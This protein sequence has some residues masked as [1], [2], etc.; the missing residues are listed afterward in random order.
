MKAEA[1]ETGSGLELPRRRS[2]PL[3]AAVR[4]LRLELGLLCLVAATAAVVAWQD[5]LLKRS[6]V[7]DPQS[8]AGFVSY[9]YGDESVGGT[10]SAATDAG[11]PFRWTCRLRPQY[12]YPFC[13]YELLWDSTG[14]REGLDLSK[15]ETV[16]I[17]FAY[18]GP[19]DSLKM[20]L[21]NHDGRYSRPGLSESNKFNKIEFPVKQGR[22]EVRLAFADFSVAE[23]W[24]TSNR[25]PPELSQPQFDN[26][27][28]IDL[29]TG[30]GAR[31]GNHDF[32]VDAIVLEGAFL[33]EAQLYLAMLCAWLAIILAFLVSRIGRLRAALSD[34]QRLQQ[35]AEREA[36]EAQEAA[37]RDHLTGLLNRLGVEQRFE[38]MIEAAPT[39]PVS[40]ILVD[41]DNFKSIN[42]SYGHGFG[43]EVLESLARILKHSV[44]AV[45][46]VGR[47]GGEEF[48]IICTGID[49][50]GT[51]AVADKL[52][53]RI[54]RFHFGDGL[55]VTASF[56][57]YW[58]AAARRAD[59]GVLVDFADIALYEAKVRGR[60]RTV[61]YEAFM[62]KAA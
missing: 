23:W 48:I 41:A 6:I 38:A 20:H 52:R 43:D 22:Q 49:E 57:T 33:T 25:I 29:Q 2:L 5:V 61:L 12:E 34:Q 8:A 40:V 11:R 19:G 58:T 24:L 18:R 36:A 44:R 47:W 17:N 28:S 51:I 54:E 59:L 32:A 14:Y 16:S 27:V 42:D 15:F 1:P 60:N 4:G 26:V 31:P 46:V 7:L 9:P 10:S 62:K 30:S 55:K 3:R 13:G 50:V 45:D 53:R 39:E 37:R 35:L 21:K 56:G